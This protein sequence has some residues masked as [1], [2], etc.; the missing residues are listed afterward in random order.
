MRRS[1][2]NTK[3]GQVSPERSL[4][5][6][7]A[8][9]WR[10]VRA[11]LIAVNAFFQ[12]F[13][14][15]L[16]IELG[17]SMLDCSDSSEIERATISIK[18]T[19][20]T[21]TNRSLTSLLIPRYSEPGLVIH[22]EKSFRN[23][24]DLVICVILLYTATIMPFT[25][26]FI[27][28][29]AMDK[30][31]FIEISIDS[32]FFVDLLLNLNTAYYEKDGELV[33]KRGKI[34]WRYLRTWMVI[35][36][37]SCFPFGYIGDNNPQ[38]NYGSLLKILRL[39]R[40][41]KLFRLARIAKMFKHFKNTSFFE[42]IQ[43][44]FQFNQS[45][46]RMASSLIAILLFIHI[47][48]C[49]WY[50][51]SVIQNNDYNTWVYQ[52][53]FADEDIGTLY[54]ISV[55]WAVATLCTVGYGDIHAFSIIEKVF[56]IFWM[57]FGVYFISFV[58]GSLSQMLSKIDSKEK[59]LLMKLAIIDEFAQDIKLS[60]EIKQR[61]RHAL[62]YST[63]KNNFS[64]NQKQ[65]IFN[66]LPKDL[67]YEISL[68]MHG[69]AAKKIRFFINKDP[70]ILAAIVPFLLPLF[71][72]R[73]EFVYIKGEY[74]EEIYFITKGKVCYVSNSDLMLSSV[75]QGEFFGEIEVVQEIERLYATR[76][77]R[78]S[79]L[80]VMRKFLI[81]SIQKDYPQIWGEFSASSFSKEMINEKALVEAAELN[82]L[83]EGKINQDE[84]K[85]NLDQRKRNNRT[86]TK[87]RLL[88]NLSKRDRH[89]ATLESLQVDISSV[90]LSLE[91]LKNEIVKLSTTKNI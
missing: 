51:L 34:W 46:M 59:V 64:W 20:R 11:K 56:S 74:A 28:T 18:N 38:S 19:R 36:L 81:S 84:Y 24:W 10:R 63:G 17:D 79:E 30:W 15:I 14:E 44:F 2:K 9:F 32:F 16:K 72:I 25:T 43:E 31:F 67:R 65:N 76:A 37:V 35:D 27:E 41:Y 90:K 60:K 1:R 6:S 45:M 39:P 80:L 49:F 89:K 71:V 57:F 61:I 33:V 40:F 26:A 54:I 12:V 23:I 77:E 47:V 73:D 66:E 88:Q 83:R 62:R 5:N 22:P 86:L 52:S 75:N 85:K 70:V 87:M 53:G 13:H 3:K 78:D 58:I 4:P 7:K 50:Y 91:G 8:A 29:G 69:G 42:K 68:V 21:S 55:Y 82:R 48:S